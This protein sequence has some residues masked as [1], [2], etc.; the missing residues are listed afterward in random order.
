MTLGYPATAA[1]VE[2][3]PVPVQLVHAEGRRASAQLR[4]FID[5]AVERL[6][7]EPVLQN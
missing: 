5:F 3:P 4:A 6:R 7:T 2:L 1:G